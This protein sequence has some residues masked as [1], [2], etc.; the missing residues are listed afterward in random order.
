MLRRSSGLIAKRSMP[1]HLLSEHTQRVFKIRGEN[2]GKVYL[3]SVLIHILLNSLFRE[4]C[5]WNVY[6]ACTYL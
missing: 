2:L 1:D 4:D 3:P 5:E 6:D